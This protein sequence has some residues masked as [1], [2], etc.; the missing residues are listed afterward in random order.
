MSISMSRER[1]RV[2]IVKGRGLRTQDT[3]ISPQP[4]A[5]C[6]GRI[7]HPRRRRKT[8]LIVEGT[9]TE[10]ATETAT[11]A[12]GGVVSRL[13]VVELLQHLLHVVELLLRLLDRRLQQLETLLLCDI[14]RA[15]CVLLLA[16]VLD[17]LT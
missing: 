16:V 11:V 4:H 14:V 5:R 9:A 17:L 3:P 2:G 1:Q 12:M 8:D 13:V 15:L 10:T 6:Q 7:I